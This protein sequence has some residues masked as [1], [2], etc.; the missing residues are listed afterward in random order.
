MD[1][2]QGGFSG[3]LVE[4]IN[5]YLQATEKRFP[6]LTYINLK[7]LRGCKRHQDSIKVFS[8]VK[9][10][11]GIRRIKNYWRINNLGQF[12]KPFTTGCRSLEFMPLLPPSLG[13]RFTHVATTKNGAPLT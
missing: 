10:A 8:K 13:D 12:S 7:T 5:Q 2:L 4:R 9:A 3:A 1:Q 11:A 6:I